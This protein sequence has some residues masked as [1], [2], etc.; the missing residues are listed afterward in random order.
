MNPSMSRRKL[1]RVG[2]ISTTGAAALLG[3]IGSQAAFG[4]QAG[5]RQLPDAGAPISL[6]VLPGG[7]KAADGQLHDA[8]V[9]SSVVLQSGV[10]TTLNIVNYD[11]GAHT[12]TAPDLGLNLMIDAGTSAQPTTTT[13]TLTIPQPGVYRWFCGL[14]CDGP[15]HFAMGDGWGGPGQEGYMAGN[16]VVV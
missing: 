15:S 13:A 10:P 2:V 7:I 3:V 8:V 9:P 11:G 16:I 6:Y 5:G 12:I 14:T 1:L 4:Q